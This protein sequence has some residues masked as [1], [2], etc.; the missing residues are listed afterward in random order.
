MA[1]P[2]VQLR[3]TPLPVLGIQAERNPHENR[4]CGQTERQ[5]E[6][7]WN[8]RHIEHY[9]DHE[10][11]RQT[12]REEEEIPALK[13]LELRTAAYTLVDSVIRHKSKEERAQNSGRNDK[14]DTGSE[15]RRSGLLRVGIAR[16]ELAVDLNAPDKA[17]N[18][19]DSINKLRGRIEI[20]RY[21]VRG[22]HDAAHT[23]ALGISAER[24]QQK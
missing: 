23:V 7:G 3:K 20:G 12:A 4:R 21:H 9:D 1:T 13:A 17:D 11:T 16:G 2:G 10:N 5:A 6:Q 22:L 18:G 24:K 19:A 14:K 8:T 15:P